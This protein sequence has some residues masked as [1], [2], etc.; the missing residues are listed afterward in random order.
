MKKTFKAVLSLIVAAIMLI[1][2]QI[3][4]FAATA[5]VFANARAWK[6][7]ENYLKNVSVIGYYANESQYDG[8]CVA[9]TD[10]G[11]DK[12]LETVGL[13]DDDYDLTRIM[14]GINVYVNKD[15]HFEAWTN[16]DPKTKDWVSGGYV[17]FTEG[18]ETESASAPKDSTSWTAA[19]CSS[20]RSE[21]PC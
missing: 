18:G 9:V 1:S 6:S 5:S 15:T 12:V 4:A 8:Y 2:I 11:I 10:C 16:Y 21:I 20:A 17:S 7:R 13:V 19:P 3:P 14:F